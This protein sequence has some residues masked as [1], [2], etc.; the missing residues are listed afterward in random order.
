MINEIKHSIKSKNSGNLIRC[1][2]SLL[3]PTVAGKI[4]F[5]KNHH[6]KIDYKNPTILDEKLLAISANEYYKN[7]LIT[8]CADKY[9]VR[10]YIEEKGLGCILNELIGVYDNTDEIDWNALPNQFAIKCNHGSGYNIV[11]TNK[12]DFNKDE[13]FAKLNYWLEED[14]SIISAEHQYHEIPRKI[15]IEKYLTDGHGSLPID[16]KFFAS[17]GNIICCLSISGRAEHSTKRFFSDEKFNGI[18]VL[19]K[20]V[21]S[22][23]AKKPKK[24][25]EMIEVAK[26]LS[27]DFPFVRVDLYETEKG[28]IFGEL[29]FT[30]MGYNHY[31]LSNEAQEF[32]G[33]KIII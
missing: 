17:R 20:C 12:A 27:K 21:D 7:P 10:E 8:K 22:F 15:I 26:T 23:D 29:T 28:V 25:D 11:V 5:F 33:S 19:N 2:K 24:Y 16:Y 30:P 13:V 4:V 32:M 6:R 14:Y 3:N 31:Y 18:S 9:A 1:F